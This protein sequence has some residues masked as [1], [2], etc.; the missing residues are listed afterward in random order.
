MKDDKFKFMDVEVLDE[1]NDNSKK[2]D[3]SKKKIAEEPSVDI[4]KRFYFS[5]EARIIV[6]IVIILLL[7]A[8]ACFL[9]IKVINHTATQ[10]VNYVET[11]DFSYQVCLKDSTCLPE[12]ATYRAEDV[13]I[14][15]IAF[16]YN[17]KYDKKVNINNKYRINSIVSVYD[18]KD[19]GVLYRKNVNLIQETP[20]EEVSGS[21]LVSEVINYKYDV[22]QGYVFKDYPDGENEAELG[23]Y[24][25]ENNETR[26]VASLVIPY[27]KETFQLNKY[28]TNA[29]RE[30]EVKVNVWDAYALVYGIFAS[31]LTIIS[32]VLIYRTTR[33]VLKVTN[34]KNEFEQEVDSILREYDNVIVVARDGY[35]S[36]MEREVV[37]LDTFEELVKIREK[38]NKSIIFSKINNVKCEFILETDDKLYKYVMKEVDFTEEDKNKLENK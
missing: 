30:T 18:K 34:N 38:E 32:L 27:S 4:T 24:V 7:F 19:H 20:I 15:K 37:K 14:I 23:F 26:K 9:A 2:T 16:K 22:Y 13:D 21:Y 5:F 28:N 10:K 6:S 29:N 35:E 11:C 31:I 8:G 3:S 1:A 36:I 17:A 12:N 33:L 25:N